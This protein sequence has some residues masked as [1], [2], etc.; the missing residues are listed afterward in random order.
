MTKS[1]KILAALAVGLY[2]T[3][4]KSKSPTRATTPTS[5]ARK[6]VPVPAPA[7][8]PPPKHAR[9]YKGPEDTYDTVRMSVDLDGS[10]NFREM[11]I[12][13]NKGNAEAQ[14]RKAGWVIDQPPQ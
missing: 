8:P 3:T 9:I 5:S 4:R 12:F 1:E 10:G 2:V 14:A 11:G 13:S 6:P 7:P